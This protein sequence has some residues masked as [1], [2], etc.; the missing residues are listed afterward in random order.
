M[1]RKISINQFLLKLARKEVI[2][3][4]DVDGLANY[5]E[6]HIQRAVWRHL[7]SSRKGTQL[8]FYSREPDGQKALAEARRFDEQGYHNTYVAIGDFKEWNQSGVVVSSSPV[9]FRLNFG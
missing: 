6:V 2:L 9:K 8:L 4:V 7:E 5:D 1:V 3:P